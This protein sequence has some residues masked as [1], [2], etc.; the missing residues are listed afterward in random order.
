MQHLL[1]FQ[2]ANFEKESGYN[3]ELVLPFQHKFW[4]TTNTLSCILNKIEDKQSV[5]NTSKPY[6][7]YYSN[8]I[9]KLP[10]EIELSL[11]GWGLTNGEE[12]VFERNALF[13]AD[14]AVSKTFLKHFDCT[15]SYNDI[16]RQVKY[17]ENFTI[18]KVSA[19]GVYYT[20]SNMISFSIKYLFGKIKNQEYKE[21]SIDENSGRI[22]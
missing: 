17:Y 20:D 9:F 5:V 10:K 4:T 21:K 8:H 13:T 6:L 7:Y 18:N 16:F 12:G 22:R 3:V 2:T 15:I 11:T 14:L 19:K 1:T